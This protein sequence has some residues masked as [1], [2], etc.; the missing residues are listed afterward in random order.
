MANKANNQEVGLDGPSMCTCGCGCDV[1]HHE[2]FSGY[3]RRCQAGDCPDP[4]EDIPERC[5]HC[6]GKS[7]LAVIEEFGWCLSDYCKHPAN[8]AAHRLAMRRGY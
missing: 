3:C 8:T 7:N 5:P 4:D 1:K 6:R 2:P